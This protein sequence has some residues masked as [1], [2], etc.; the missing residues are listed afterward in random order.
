MRLILDPNWTFEQIVQ[1]AWQ[2]YPS[3]REFA[4]Y[5]IN[6]IK[7]WGNVVGKA[8]ALRKLHE[9]VSENGTKKRAAECA[10]MSYSTLRGIERFYESLPDDFLTIRIPINHKFLFGSTLDIEEDL[11]NE[12]KSISSGNPVRTICDSF[13]KY[14][15]GF[16]NA[17]GGRIL[18]GIQDVNAIVEGVT[19]SAKDRDDIRIG[20]QN[21]IN[22]I[23]PKVDP[24][25]FKVSFIEVEGGEENLFV[26]VVEIPKANTTR[27]FFSE[28]GKCWVRVNG[29]TQ[30]INGPVIQELILSRQKYFS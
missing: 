17:E 7:A 16:L 14:A 15:I 8:D 18:W 28:S 2:A 1:A 11:H 27:I 24:T 29:V 4:G 12:F 30:M 20:I 9:F 5:R 21:K 13:T 3:P 22:N 25:P 10:S 23:Q 6:A 19:L 26:V